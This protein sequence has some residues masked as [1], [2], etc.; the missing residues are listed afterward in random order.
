MVVPRPVWITGQMRN[1]LH[2]SLSDM[3]QSSSDVAGLAQALPEVYQP[4]FGHPEL[5]EAVSRPSR[6]RLDHI[7]SLYKAVEALLGRPLR[8]LDLGCAQGFFSHHLSALGALVHGVDYLDAN[9]L[10]CKALA[11][12]RGDVGITFDTGEIENVVGRLSAKQYD[13]VLGLSVFHHLVHEKGAPHV[14]ALVNE[15]ARKAYACVFEMALAE[16]PLYWAASQP[17]FI[18]SRT[19]KRLRLRS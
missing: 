12:E 18:A 10:L 7:V 14:G 11:E 17:P 5:S 8:V 13:L 1:I 6:D 3:M 16:E 19:V 9:I 2:F 15:L 4:I